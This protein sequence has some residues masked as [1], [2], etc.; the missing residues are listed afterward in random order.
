MTL[1]SLERGQST[2][3]LFS[4]EI[5]FDA[6]VRAQRAELL[7]FLRPRTSSED[8]AQDVAHESLIRLMCYRG[9]AP[10]PWTPLLHRIAINALND[11][12][13][14]A[15]TRHEGRHIGLA[16]GAAELTS[17]KPTHEGVATRQEL[18]VLQHAVLALPEHCRQIFLLN[19]IEGMSYSEIANH[20]SISVKAVEKYVSKALRLLRE[21]MPTFNQETDK[22]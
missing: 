12:M 3:Q 11:R 10:E 2:T 6:F 17:A 7:R 15:E 13:H 4:M 20:C 8:D 16:A 1:E 9:H 5:A 21:R 18:A 14:R 22:T 19:R